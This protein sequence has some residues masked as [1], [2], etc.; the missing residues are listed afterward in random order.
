MTTQCYAM[1]NTW[2]KEHEPKVNRN[3]FCRFKDDVI[4]AIFVR[5]AW[6]RNN[7]SDTLTGL[8]SWYTS[9]NYFTVL[10]CSLVRN[11]YHL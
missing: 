9:R 6:H 7:C 4:G 1:F 8:T 11:P 3:S 5:S 10:P 2:K